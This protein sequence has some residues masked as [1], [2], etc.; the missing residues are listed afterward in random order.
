MNWYHW[1]FIAS[2]ACAWPISK[3]SVYKGVMFDKVKEGHRL[4]YFIFNGA[5]LILVSPVCLIYGIFKVFILP[6]FRV[7]NWM[8]ARRFY[9][10]MESSRLIKR[11]KKLQ[12]RY[13]ELTFI[14]QRR[15]D[16]RKKDQ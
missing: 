4:R 1:Y 7:T 2:C 5:I 9:I 8:K 11:A 12:G 14:I 16:E 15:E 6:F 13:E 3:T 10:V